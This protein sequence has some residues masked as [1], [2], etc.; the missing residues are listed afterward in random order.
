MSGSVTLTGAN[1][2]QFQILPGNTCSNATLHQY[3]TCT[4]TVAFKPTLPADTGAWSV[5]FPDNAAGHPHT[6]ALSG[7]G[8][9]EQALNGGLNIY[10]ST[11]K[12]PSNWAAAQFSLSD[13]KDTINK[14]EGMAALKISGQPGKTKTLTQTRAV[15]GAAGN[16]FVLSLWRKGTSIP[17]TAGLVRAQVLFYSGSSLVQTATL[18]LPNGAYNWTQ[19]KL[20]FT[21]AHAYTKVVIKLTYSKGSGTVWFDGLSLLKIAVVKRGHHAKTSEFS[22]QSNG[23]RRSPRT[24][25]PLNVPTTLL[26]LPVASSILRRVTYFLVTYCA[27]R[28]TS[29]VF[30]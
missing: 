29:P 28:D 13:G 17:G 6:V 9:I 24:P 19:Q 21:V 22:P 3:Q 11:S 16:A 7:K 20:A 30:A 18:T 4:V 2:G 1:P 8:G 26:C 15:G 23:A 5:R 14:K 10:A 27:A 12:I 25:D